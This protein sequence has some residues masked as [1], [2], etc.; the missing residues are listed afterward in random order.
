MSVFG[1]QKSLIAS[2]EA[3]LKL[4]TTLVGLNWYSNV[5]VFLQPY[6]LPAVLM[7]SFRNSPTVERERD[8]LNTHERTLELRFELRST[9][10]APVDY[11][12]IADAIYSEL[13]SYKKTD[14]TV[15]YVGNP[16]FQIGLDQNQPGEVAATL[17]VPVYYLGRP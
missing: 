11:E 10:D 15:S 6:E 16:T 1:T 3:Y 4:N 7:Y 13:L 17:D 8:T 9:P 2:I 14:K 12:A 5:V